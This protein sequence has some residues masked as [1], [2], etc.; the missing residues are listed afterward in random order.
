MSKVN[1]VTNL[2]HN[3]DGWCR[4]IDLH[5]RSRFPHLNTRLFKL[6]DYEYQLY[7]VDSVD[8]FD[9]ISDAFNREV[10]FVTAPIKLVMN[11]P[12]TYK[13]EIE[14]ITDDKIPSKFEGYP[15]TNTQ[16]YSHILSIHP[17]VKVSKIEEDHDNRLIIVELAGRYES[18]VV[19][20]VEETAAALK[21]PYSYKVRIGGE[22]T[23]NFKT[24]DEVFNI[25]PSQTKS[26]LN[27]AFIERD[28]ALW[29]ENIE[30]IYN[31]SYQKSDLYFFDP[32]KS[33][34]LVN[35]SK[36]QNANLRN[37]L[38]LYDVVYCVLPLAHKMSNFLVNQKISKDEIL[39][40]VKRGRLKILNMQPESRLD[41]GFIN[42]AFQEN[43]SAVV[44]RRALSALC[45]IDLVEMNQSYALSDPDLDKYI[46][47]LVQEVSKLTGK[48]IGTVS[49]FLLWPKQALRRSLD[50]LNQAGPM[51]ISRYGINNPII[52]S[53]PAENKEKIKFEFIVNSDQI[54][55]SHAL[56]ATYFPFFV[57]GG[58]YSDH[59]YALMM[60]KMLN[61]FKNSSCHNISNLVDVE[62]IK[63]AQNPS[64]GLISAFDI[65]DYIPVLEFEEEISS[66]VV[67]NGMNSLF[68]ELN[69]LNREGRSQ[70]IS[71][72]NVEVDKA[73]RN[74]N[75]SK[76]ALDLGED[77]LGLFIP[78]WTTA[79]K[80]VKGGTKM[81]MDKFPAIQNVSEFIEDKTSKESG[82]NRNISVLTQVNR[83]AKLK[84]EFK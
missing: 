8:E 59:P 73:L 20:G 74:K 24:S 78:F 39:R 44:S 26:E 66:S 4:R 75:V 16:I 77:T 10:K 23:S 46:Y 76:H 12:E 79:K 54:H 82:K 45:A 27:C 41:Y 11:I 64:L 49:N 71:E 38:L 52:D 33:A 31:G 37:H 32:S 63:S 2:I 14:K 57:D 28:E 30:N 61:F 70:R 35:F 68:S 9:V 51:G 47:P 34:C 65:N 25:A 42:E 62:N 55:L 60:G 6:D 19:V 84:R 80:L 83:V 50:S 48:D 1:G 21:G 29:Y 53:L 81:A 40:L 67:R 15:L 56:D 22:L 18:D 17:N 36:F 5:F 3:Y 13:I 58:K 72:Y 43:P 69:L 7:L